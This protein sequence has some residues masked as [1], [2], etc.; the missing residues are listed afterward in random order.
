[1][2]MKKNT[3]ILIVAV[4]IILA[5]SVHA[6]VVVHKKSVTPEP[7]KTATT[8][9]DPSSL[10][11]IQK[12]NIPW[13]AETAHLGERLS[14][15][16]LPGLAEEG[17]VLHTHQ[18]LDIF[19]DGAHTDVPAEI[20]IGTGFISPIHTHDATGIIHVES[21]TLQAYSLGQFFDIWGLRFTNECI[22]GYCASESKSLRVYVNG[23]LYQ[24]DPRQIALEAHQEIVI[25]YGTP[26]E[27]PNPIPKAY[28]FPRDY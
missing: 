20:G 17:T 9:S 27:L 1:M 28:E 18:H 25:A 2:S 3:I 5:L 6:Y 22:G 8:I 13:V 23:E 12:G 16:G 15:I 21:P 11:G 24:G 26:T 10:A 19:I 7:L 14:A 4:L